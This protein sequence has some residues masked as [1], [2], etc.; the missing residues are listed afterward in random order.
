[1]LVSWAQ[2]VGYIHD[3]KMISNC[4]DFID[5]KAQVN[6]SDLSPNLCH[7]VPTLYH[8][9]VKHLKDFASPKGHEPGINRNPIKPQSSANREKSISGYHSPDHEHQSA[10]DGALSIISNNRNL[11]TESNVMQQD[12]MDENDSK[13]ES[14]PSRTRSKKKG[15][16]ED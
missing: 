13:L 2:Q 6:A 16:I 14:N 8:Y 9:L 5:S 15:R 11:L 7:Y 12:L 10:N 1:M 3:H 4:L